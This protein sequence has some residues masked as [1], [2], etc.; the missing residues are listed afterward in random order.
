M[1]SDKRATIADVAEKAGVSLGTAS[2]ALNGK[3]R[4]H[5]LLRER[6]LAVARELGYQPHP[7]AQALRTGR[8]RTIGF[9]VAF[10][11][12]PTI[13]PI[14]QSASRAAHEAGY[15]LMI[16][17]TEYDPALE[18][19]Q[20]EG[21]A[22]Q[23]V[24]AVIAFHP[25]DDPEPYL[26]AQ[27]AGVQLLL[28]DHRPA[29]V[30]ADLATSDHQATMREAVGHLLASGRRRV[31]LLLNTVTI[32]QRRM[33]GYDDAYKLAGLLAPPDL[34]VTGLLTEEVTFAAVDELLAR[35]DPPDAV[36]AGVG[37]LV[38]W[39]LARLR[40]RGVTI[41]DDMA[42][43]GSGDRR[44]GR[45]IEP[46]LSMIEIDGQEHGRRLVELVLERLES[47]PALPPAREVLLPS[48]FVARASS[49]PAAVRPSLATLALRET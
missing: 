37:L 25:G 10:I 38:Q 8:N 43:V 16:C 6:V 45:L 5:T 48:R 11:S 7:L 26:L 33:A 9:S 13:P 49:A 29:G 3:G 12:N 30:V 40:G 15:N 20:L 4:V 35:P 42:F 14:L 46:P 2:N 32:N 21:L 18:R 31:A 47:G 17:V 28:V 27:Q 41:P 24:A 34:V 23:R 22:R 1:A 44:W 36:V 19:A 39:T